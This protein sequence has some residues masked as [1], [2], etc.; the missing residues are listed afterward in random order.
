MSNLMIIFV[1]WFFILVLHSSYSRVMT[2]VEGELI[3]EVL[4]PEEEELHHDHR[5]D[6]ERSPCLV[7]PFYIITLTS[8]NPILLVDVRWL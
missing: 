7:D 4:E 5:D 2:K 6:L 3:R 8:N 1:K